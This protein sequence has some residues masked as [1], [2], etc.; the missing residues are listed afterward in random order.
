MCVQ[1]LCSEEVL[2]NEGVLFGC[3]FCEGRR[4]VVQVDFKIVV[5]HIDLQL[6]RVCFVHWGVL[7]APHRFC[8]TPV[9]GEL[10]LGVAHIPR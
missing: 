1:I 9:C 4:K 7:C 3:T 8:A 10:Q 5:L 6:T 2:I